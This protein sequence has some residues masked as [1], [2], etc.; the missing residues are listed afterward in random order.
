MSENSRD[1]VIMIARNDKDDDLDKTIDTHC[2]FLGLDHHEGTEADSHSLQCGRVWANEYHPGR[3]DRHR[4][5]DQKIE[6]SGQ[7]HQ[8]TKSRLHQAQSCYQKI[9][10]QARQQDQAGSGEEYCVYPFGGQSLYRGGRC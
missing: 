7:S 3:A 5:T 2:H 9:R 8:E 10:W 1:L 6:E 4:I